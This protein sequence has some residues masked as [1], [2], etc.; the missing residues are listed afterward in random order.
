MLICGPGKEI[1]FYGLRSILCL[2]CEVSISSK[3][4]EWLFKKSTAINKATLQWNSQSLIHA[5]ILRMW[6][7]GGLTFSSSG[8]RPVAQQCGKARNK[9]GRY[10]RDKCQWCLGNFLDG[11]AASMK[12]R[13]CMDPWGLVQEPVINS[14]TYGTE[15]KVGIFR[16]KY[17]KGLVHI[18]GS[19]LAG[20]LYASAWV[21]FLCTWILSL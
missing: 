11:R 19:S 10:S 7:R 15:T 2:A 18:L 12:V 16:Q 14:K 6:H 5:W 13:M 4:V 21:G 17:L 3:Y 9:Q 1:N 20:G 8:F